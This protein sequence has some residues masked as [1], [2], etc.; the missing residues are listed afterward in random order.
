M[1]DFSRYLREGLSPASTVPSQYPPDFS[2]YLREGLSPAS[3]LKFRKD[4]VLSVVE[5]NFN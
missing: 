1:L 4:E 5:M 3:T 2:R